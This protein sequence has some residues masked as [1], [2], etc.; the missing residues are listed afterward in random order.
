VPKKQTPCC[1][2]EEDTADPLAVVVRMLTFPGVTVNE[3]SCGIPYALKLATFSCCSDVFAINAYVLSKKYRPK[4][5][6]GPDTAR[7]ETASILTDIP[8]TERELASPI[9][10]ASI[11]YCE[12]V[13]LWLPA[14]MVKK[15]PQE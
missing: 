7:T 4:P 15:S 2:F 12:S 10:S 5:T 3:D 1:L 14:V 13:A 9:R 11:S 6:L 8:V